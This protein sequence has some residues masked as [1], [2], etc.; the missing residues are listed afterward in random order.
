MKKAARVLLTALL[1]MAVVSSFSF[2]GGQTEK[3]GEAATGKTVSQAKKIGISLFYRRDEFYKDLETGFIDGAKKYGFDVNIQ[4]ADADPSKQMQQ[5]EDF[6]A[7]KVDLIAFAA[8]DPAGLVPAV[9]EANKANIPVITFDGSIVGG[10]ELV[11]F[12]GMDNYKAGVMAG[13]WAKEY[14]QKHLGGKA[15]VVILDFPQSAVVCGDRV[16]GFIATL[17]DMAG[18]KIVAQQDGKASRTESMSVMENILTANPKIDIV[19]AINDDTAFGGIA[20]CEAAGRK[21]MVFVDVGWSQELFEKLKKDDPYMK[22]SAVQNPYLMGM[23][24][25]EAIK[26]YFEGKT[27]PKEILQESILT[28]K[29]NVDQLGWEQIVAK[30]K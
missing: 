9:K 19:F 1:L 27:L 17:K 28:T 10:A 3:K 4:D 6:I 21:E 22:A 24:T 15:N 16:R 23:G 7:S 8:A 14:I 18:V 2:A 5:I 30:R 12:V 20:A 29:E 13:T 25:M 26:Q 11:T